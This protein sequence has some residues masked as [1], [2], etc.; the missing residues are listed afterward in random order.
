MAINESHAPPAAIPPVS[1]PLTS[2][3]LPPP[4]TLPSTRA[5]WDSHQPALPPPPAPPPTSA[6]APAHHPLQQ[7]PPQQPPQQQP[8]Q[9]PQQPPHPYAPPQPMIP[10]QPLPAASATSPQRPRSDSQNGYR[11]LNVKDALSYLDQV[12]MQFAEHPEVYN[13]FLDIMKDF[14]SQAIDTP[15]VIERVSTLFRG[16]PLLIS[17]FNTFLPPGYCIEC[18]TDEHGQDVIKV[19]T[20]QGINLS[21]AGEPIRLGGSESA[22]P[23]D[24]VYYGH[25]YSY[26]GPQGAQ[27]SA[28]QAPSA[29]S[30]ANAA[31][32]LAQSAQQQVH[33]SSNAPRYG[34]TPPPSQNAPSTHPH[35]P[36]APP[37]SHYPMQQPYTAAPPPPPPPQD[38]AMSHR[39][40][41]VEFNH[42]I[43][44]VNK[45]KNRFASEPDVYKQFLEIL[46]TY[47]K[48]QRPIQEVYSQVQSLFNGDNDLLAEFK[49]FL[50]DSTG[51]P[52][53]Y[54]SGPHGN[55]KGLVMVPGLPS[56]GAAPQ[57]RRKRPTTLIQSDLS[58]RTK[59]EHGQQDDAQ[60][61]QVRGGLVEEDVI[62]PFVTGEEV[63]FFDR[64]KKY[65]GSKVTYHAFLKVLH[66]FSQ[67]I[68]DQN[69]LVNR[70]EGFLGGNKEL[71]DLFKTLVGYDPKDELIE[72]VPDD[73]RKPALD[74]AEAYGPSYRVI[75]KSSQNQVCSGKD[76]LC[77]EVLNDK[78]VSHP[79]WASEDSV[80]VA[81]KKNQY[82]EALHRV[83][84]ERYD[85]DLNVEANLNT[86]AL[87]EPI[88]KK[89]ST[90]STEEKHEFTLPIGLGG[91]SKTIYQRI[92]KKIY[93]SEK[94]LEVIALL[95]SNPAMA[96]PIVLKRLK[97][98][99][100]EWKR[101]QREWNKI[102]R[103]VEALN[104]LKALDYQGITFKQR[105]KRQT[106]DKYLM[107]EIEERKLQQLDEQQ[108]LL[109][110]RDNV[111][112]V[113]APDT[114]KEDGKTRV[115]LAPPRRPPQF[116]FSIPDADRLGDMTRLIRVFLAVHVATY[117]A[118][119]QERMAQLLDDLL[120]V[121]FDVASI[122]PV[123]PDAKKKTALATEDQPHKKD[124]SPED[125]EEDEEED[126]DAPADDDDDDELE[127]EEDDDDQEDDTHSSYDS[128]G[129]AVMTSTRQTAAMRRPSARIGP[130]RMQQ[131][132]TIDDEASTATDDH[133]SA[134][135]TQQKDT[136]MTDATS[137]DAAI[138]SHTP[139]DAK[140][141][142]N[143]SI[144]LDAA[145]ADSADAVTPVV[146]A[147]AQPMD[148]DTTPPI[149][150]AALAKRHMFNLFA[151]SEMYCFFRL[152]QIIYARLLAMYQL[153][154][155][156]KQNPEK[157][158]AKLKAPV[159][160]H[161]KAKRMDGHQMDFS[162]GYYEALL[163]LI[164]KLL[165]GTIDNSLF[166]EMARYM[167]GNRV[168]E[169][170]T[171]DRVLAALVRH[172]HVMVSTENTTALVHLFRKHHEQEDMDAE[173]LGDYRVA[174]EQLLGKDEA[175]FNIAFDTVRRR[176]AIQL[177]GYDD[178]CQPMARNDYEDYVASYIDSDNPT[179]GINQTLLTKRF[180]SRNRMRCNEDEARQHIHLRSG[181]QYKIC[182]D[183]YHMFY[184]NGTEDV[185]AR[186]PTHNTPTNAATATSSALD[187]MDA[188]TRGVENKEQQEA[189]ARK[190]LFAPI[191]AQTSS[192]S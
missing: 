176:L 85:Y 144:A 38:D 27:T 43:N 81:A 100:D 88:M 45:I 39:R 157:T 159:N 9:Q 155:D 116:T 131:P 34:Q 18:M 2:S 63:A 40:A 148:T 102:W 42:A 74:A 93:G 25:L 146:S 162:Y 70:V 173:K 79:T 163:V 166:E 10:P 48:E 73:A 87:L 6:P 154:E 143:A 71:F 68:V 54:T 109:H 94:G 177:L 92:I 147:S 84:E 23:H 180:L 16:H 101:A 115:L 107:T 62:R 47:Q 175:L 13:K 21:N 185:F 3:P 5:P 24:P 178:E 52:A 164:E 98:K 161:L 44:Y 191:T 57:Q 165:Q 190:L 78:Y 187:T 182:H 149:D 32:T 183:T 20:P 127:E 95:H 17:G 1:A 169:L 132:A 188:W 184:I 30:Q 59:R 15:G 28:Q 126:D 83:E 125:E 104:Y 19:T 55:R 118:A 69:V 114:Q 141:D 49:Q 82:E 150:P 11:P 22:P 110:E 124:A 61:S 56:V 137:T 111:D 76:E 50:P 75:P 145:A 140:N 130:A 186:L 181:M 12:K 8:S 4:P 160:L 103:E 122:Q 53:V 105:D 139:I 67:Q 91:P 135:Q 128:D 108:Q 133:D 35:H 31:H 106:T 138:A 99:D 96:V 65:I 172:V 86:I 29:T 158:K 153:N 51:P 112:H 168:Y 136:K 14:K 80:Y 60:T 129:D 192:T 77:L 64:V 123:Q 121:F 151:D 33:P 174:V 189:D 7:Q 119:A 171:I 36:H 156:Y 26:G 58:K 90:M 72:N 170:F 113:V 89:I 46:Q 120:P 142:E 152:Y 167:F 66:L 37:P 134:S 117:D 97:Q 179:K 41:P